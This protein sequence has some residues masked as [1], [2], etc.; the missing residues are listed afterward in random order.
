MIVNHRQHSSLSK[1]ANRRP[2]SAVR[3]R[4]QSRL[5]LFLT[6]GPGA[7]AIAFQCVRFYAASPARVLQAFAFGGLL[8]LLTWKVRA[9][10]AL[11]AATGGMCTTALYLATPGLHTALWPLLSLLL[12]TLAAT[13]FGRARKQTLGIAEGPHGRVAAQVAANLGVAVLASVALDLSRP[14]NVSAMRVALAAAL[15]EAAADTLSS[16]FGEVLGGEPRLLTTFRR[17]PIGT[18]GAVSV[19][20]TIAG[21]AGTVT[22]AATA[23]FALNLAPLQAAIVAI[24]AIAGLFA[25]SLLGA[26]VERSGWLNND[27]VNFLS[28]LVSATLAALLAVHF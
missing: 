7:A 6:I 4:W 18:D 27:A 12:L 16:E 8:A 19:A 28:T 21:F 17:V 10:T 15:A 11:A 2:S 14:F 25:D 5:T 20:G 3:L 24:A 1:A 23:Y 13:R 22:V 26:V 9:A